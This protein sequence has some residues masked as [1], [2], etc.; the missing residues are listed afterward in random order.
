MSTQRF[1]SRCVGDVLGVFLSE[2]QLNADRGSGYMKCHKNIVYYC[3]ML[4]LLLF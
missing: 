2:V 1:L 4:H 3:H